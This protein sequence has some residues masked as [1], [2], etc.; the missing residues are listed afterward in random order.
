M[1]DK[2]MISKNIIDSD[3]F[4][5][6]PTSARMLYID[7]AVR[8]DD[9]GFISPRRVM[10]VTGA[11]DDDLRILVSKRYLIPFDTGVVVITDWLYHNIIRKDMYHQTIYTKEKE[12]LRIPTRKADD[13]SYKKTKLIDLEAY[14]H[15][16]HLYDDR[17]F[18]AHP[19]LNDN[20]ELICPSQET[21]IANIKNIIKDIFIKPPIFIK[22]IVD[23]LTE[24]LQEK[25]YVYENSEEKL[26]I[27]LDNK[28]Y[29]HMDLGMKKNLFKT[30]WS[31][32]FCKPKD[33]DCQN[34]LDINRK[35]LKVLF[36]SFNSEAIK[37][38]SENADLFTVATDNKC[39]HNLILFLS[40][41]SELYSPL[42]S[43]V[44][45]HIDKAIKESGDDFFI[46]W[47]VKGEE[48]HLKALK[49]NT[50]LNVKKIDIDWGVQHYKECG[51]YSE[52]L[53][54]FIIHYGN[55]NSFDMADTRYTYIIRPFLKDFT[56]D[57]LELLI[58]K[59]EDNNQLN[60]RRLARMSNQEIYDIAKCKL[61][62][63]YKYPPNFSYKLKQ[64]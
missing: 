62:S 15:I 27:F 51:L 29:A 54:F 26:K 34:N 13:L 53:E 38:V 52:L 42:N 63:D 50:E 5:S 6:M 8:A 21:T 35:A 20:Y 2:R 10:K 60:S 3:K 44:K 47:F 49:N 37:Y 9:D 56:R 22:N 43:D 36:Y 17:N 55:S 4:L 28:Y 11:S 41:I 19:A 24:D 7:L 12:L 48:E 45:E 31:F 16:N 23:M 57:Q 33:P 30:L 58:N 1:A 64:D 39:I 46:S 14:T 25:K 32:C 59:I 18:S 40:A 61:P